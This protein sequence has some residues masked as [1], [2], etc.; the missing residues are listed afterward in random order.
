MGWAT[1]LFKRAASSSSRGVVSWGSFLSAEGG[2]SD[3]K[4]PLDLPQDLSLIDI[5][6]SLPKLSTLA[7]GGT[8]QVTNTQFF[9]SDC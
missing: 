1:N 2:L 8:T 5:E 3:K 9:I 6:T 7:A 4:A